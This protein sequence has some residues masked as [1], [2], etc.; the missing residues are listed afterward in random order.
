MT[1]YKT[2]LFPDSRIASIDVCEIGKHKHHIVGLLEFDVTDSRR[3]IRE[4]NK[5]NQTKISFNAWLIHVIGKT[6]KKHETAS[7]YL[8]GKNNLMIFDDINISIIVEK[9]LDGTKV[10]FPL[11]IEKVNEISIE[12]IAAKISM[13]KNQE[14]TQKDITLQKKAKQAE[15]IYYLLPRFLRLLFWK[16]LLKHPKFAFNRMGNVAFTSIGMMGKINGW[17]IPISVHPICFGIGSIIKKPAV[18]D[19]EIAIREILNAS[20][21][22]DHDVMDGAP[23]A[24]FINEL[25]TNIENGLNL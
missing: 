16:Y 22:I 13:A 11:V 5:K 20:I 4:Y 12:S 2:E 8:I 19:N 18:I 10:P 17:F 14:L 21:L 9:K 23:M 7:S 25:R 1:N 6:I 15:R 3:K 24:R